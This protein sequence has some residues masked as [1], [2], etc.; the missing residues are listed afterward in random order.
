MTAHVVTVWDLASLKLGSQP[1]EIPLFASLRPFQAKIVVLMGQLA[2]AQPGDYI[3]RRGERREELYVLLGGEVDILGGGDTVIRTLSRGDVIGE[4]G[5]VRH[6]P[7]SA[8]A[9]VRETTEYLV[10][11]SAFLDRIQRRYPRIAATVFLNL[12]RILS[13]RL[14]NTT[15]QLVARNEAIEP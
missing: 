9:V 10:L 5:L 4:M 8:D 11:D 3:T 6:V 14:E 12:T 15:N 1:H 7:R 2:R 13:D